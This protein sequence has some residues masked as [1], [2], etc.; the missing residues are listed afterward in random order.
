MGEGEEEV[1]SKGS[2]EED[3]NLDEVFKFEWDEPWNEDEKRETGKDDVGMGREGKELIESFLE[4]VVAKEF[5]KLIWFGSFEDVVDDEK[6]CW[7]RFSDDDNWFWFGDIVLVVDVGVDDCIRFSD[8]DNWFWFGATLLVGVTVSA[9]TWAISGLLFFSISKTGWWL[10]GT[11]FWV[12]SEEIWVGP[13]KTMFSTGFW[14]FAKI[15]EKVNSGVES[16]RLPAPTKP[17]PGL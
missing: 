7:V 6:E 11:A 12:V 3:V 15:S 8:D 9:A 4:S 14:C 10:L 1:G 13:G 5:D 2:G 17:P 16:D